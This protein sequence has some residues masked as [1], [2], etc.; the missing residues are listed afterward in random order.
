MNPLLKMNKQNSSIVVETGKN[1]GNYHFHTE[2]EHI[3]LKII[4]S[5]NNET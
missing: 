3:I 2:M 5:I 1:V 4:E